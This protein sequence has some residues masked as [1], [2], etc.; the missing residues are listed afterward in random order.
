MPGRP[1]SSGERS[2]EALKK[3]TWLHYA[4]IVGSDI[5]IR[6]MQCPWEI[7][8]KLPSQKIV[9]FRRLWQGSGSVGG[10]FGGCPQNS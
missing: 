9:S 4:C 6:K 5:S 1:K 7:K 8:K 3:T 10:T 2:T